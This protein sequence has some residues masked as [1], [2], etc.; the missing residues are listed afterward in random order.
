MIT[1]HKA[2]IPHHA[3]ECGSDKRTCVRVLLIQETWFQNIISASCNLR[4]FP[5][6]LSHAVSP[7]A[8]RSLFTAGKPP[9]TGS[10]VWKLD[11]ISP[12]FCGQYIQAE[13]KCVNVNIWY[14]PSHFP[15]WSCWLVLLPTHTQIYA[16]C[17]FLQPA[18][19]GGLCIKK[20]WFSQQKKGK[21][22]FPGQWMSLFPVLIHFCV[23]VF[24]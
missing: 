2:T 14:L 10:A 19:I 23:C 4:H 3:E 22:S 15:M 8:G 12:H 5:S 24:L 11:G 9:A 16:L 17:E 6:A 13:E 1:P 18:C 20:K 7:Y 21:Q